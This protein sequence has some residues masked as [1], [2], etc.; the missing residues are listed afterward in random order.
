MFTR[1]VKTWSMLLLLHSL[2]FELVLPGGS[3]LL[4]RASILY[5]YIFFANSVVKLFMDNNDIACE[6]MDKVPFHREDF[7][8]ASFN[9]NRYQ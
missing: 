8:D 1:P 4:F 5:V 9:E 3:P 6:C 2:P 7:L